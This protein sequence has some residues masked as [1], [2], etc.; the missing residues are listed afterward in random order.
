MGDLLDII[1]ASVPA[2][3]KHKK[4]HPA[5]KTFQALRIATNQEWKELQ[6]FLDAILPLLAP[7]G[8]VVIVS[9]HSG[10]DRVVKHT[11]KEWG[12][13]GLGI[14]LTKKP[15]GPSEKELS[16]NPRSRSALLRAFEKHI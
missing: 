10:E 9:F 2:G 3:Y 8:R 12:K 15:L 5:T 4:T 6:D 13:D 1:D 7:G 16:K 14:I 11:F